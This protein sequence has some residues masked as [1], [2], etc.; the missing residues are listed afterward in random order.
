MSVTLSMLSTSDN[1]YNP[2]DDYDEWYAWDESAGYHSS[3]YL[4]RI[5]KVSTETSE[6]DQR[7]AIEVAIDEIVEMNPT[8]MHIK[9]TREAEDTL[10]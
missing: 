3:G 2:F 7:R 4:A 8:G 5:A 10:T 9:V 6:A 1:P